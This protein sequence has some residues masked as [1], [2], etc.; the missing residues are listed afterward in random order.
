MR[1]P[2]ELARVQPSTDETTEQP[3]WCLEA[4]ARHGP[5]SPPLP[6]VGNL[7]QTTDHTTAPRIR[8]KSHGEAPRPL[9][10][11]PLR[12]GRLARNSRPWAHTA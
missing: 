9:T 5:D 12:A 8:S 3:L 1:G 7:G 11:L 4:A 6:R 10:T 2:Q